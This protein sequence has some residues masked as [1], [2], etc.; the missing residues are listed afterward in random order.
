M[1]NFEDI[2][3]EYEHMI[4]NVAYRMLGN[5]E[6]ARDI[7]QDAIIRAYE[8]FNQY[9]GKS[10]F[11]TWI[12]RITV[13]LCIDHLRKNKVR[14]I[15]LIENMKYNAGYKDDLNDPQYFVEN[16]E[17]GSVIIK[18]LNKL[19]PEYKAVIVLRDI[20]GFTYEEIARILGIKMS[21]L[22]SRLIRARNMLK[23]SI[24]KNKTFKG[25]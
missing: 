2:I 20:Y 19:K 6:D 5:E 14:R 11:A 24:K 15:E 10:S 25:I 13:N 21:T 9:K 17:L 12:Y 1:N 7:A 22:K 16:A 18:E 23:E 8:K 3:K 4:Y